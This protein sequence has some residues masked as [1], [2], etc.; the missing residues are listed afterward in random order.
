MYNTKRAA[1]CL[2]KVVILL[3]L[4]QGMLTCTKIVPGFGQPTYAFA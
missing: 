1:S 4:K 2:Q 3:S